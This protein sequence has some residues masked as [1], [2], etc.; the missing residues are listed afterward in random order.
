M[1]Y[2]G[3]QQKYIYYCGK[4]ISIIGS[5]IVTIEKMS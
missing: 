4:V 2:G 3:A 1:H 5:L